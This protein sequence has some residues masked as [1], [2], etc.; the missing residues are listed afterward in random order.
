MSSKARRKSKS[1]FPPAQDLWQG[2]WWWTAILV[3]TIVLVYHRM[4]HA[5]FIWD[6]NEHLV[7][8]PCI[9]GPLGFKDIWT[10]SRAFYYPL[11]LT[12][13]WVLYKL[14]GLNPLPFHLLNVFIHAASAVLLWRVLRKLGAR[15]AWLGAALWA[16]HPVMVQSVAWITELKNT[17]SCFFYLLSILFFLKTDNEKP[18]QRHVYLGL[19]L[20]FFAM[21][22]TS[23]SATAMLPAVLVLCLWWQ[24]RSGFRWR[25]LT[26]IFPFLLIS[27]VASGWTVW[28]QRF[29]S[30]ALG[31]EFSQTWPE[32]LIIAGRDIWFYLS[33]LF[34]P[35]SL[36]FIYPRWNVDPTK[37]ASFL[38]LLA[39]L[40]GLL[41]LWWKRN[42]PLRP[43][44]LAAAYFVLSLF[45]VL[46][47]F[48]VYFFRYS[49]VSDH[50]QYL[51]AMGP[52]ALIASGI[53]VGAA[54]LKKNSSELQTAIGAALLVILT[55]LT[56][57]QTRNYADAKSL[58]RATIE[59]N[60][61][62]WL[63]YNN[64]GAISF[65]EQ[66]WDEAI[67]CYEKARAIEPYPIPETLHNLGNSFFAKNDFAQAIGV[68]QAALRA[69]PDDI[70]ARNN[71]AISLIATGNIN[72]AIEQFAEALRFDSNDPDTHYNLGLL[73][74]QLGRPEEALAHLTEAVRLKPDYEKAKQKLRA[75][76]V[77]VL[78]RGLQDQ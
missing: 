27:A 76:G 71:L 11:V 51:A 64:L 52:L 54:F 5:S 29:H 16:L 45:P 59:K 42:G 14:V 7:Q 31:V 22:I 18:R 43:V 1:D 56:W 46:S 9:V 55:T 57:R 37:L 62:C 53:A 78:P 75:L 25:D 60:P 28:E 41:L 23:K 49:F 15:A 26:V 74:I 69:R 20:L 68:Y 24:R 50:F 32:R 61:N 6:D 47:F 72:Q 19:S 10:S 66:R 65:Q 70:K 63:A 67:S 36:V 4:W 21:S 34:W 8:N 33:K 30:G 39:A 40:G 35:N 12:S 48:N 3:A 58:Y 17:Q 73:F 2:Q 77:S 13:F 38:P 44:F